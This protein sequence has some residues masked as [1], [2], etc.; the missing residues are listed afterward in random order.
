MHQKKATEKEAA[1]SRRRFKYE[2]HGAG[3]AHFAILNKGDD[4]CDDFYGFLKAFE[5]RLQDLP[6]GNFVIG[7]A[8]NGSSAGGR[9]V[10]KNFD[11]VNAL[12]IDRDGTGPTVKKLKALSV[13][14]DLIVHTSPNRFHAYWLVKDCT[15]KEFKR[16]QKL[17]AKK[18]GTDPSV[19]DVSR[20][21]RMPG[22]VNNKYDEPFYVWAEYGEPRDKALIPPELFEALGISLG[23]SATQADDAVNAAVKAQA[24]QPAATL[25]KLKPL[26]LSIP[27]D[28]RGIWMKVGQ[29]IH[30][31]LPS[32][33]GFK[34]WTDWSQSSAKFNAEEQRK[35]WDGF[36]SDREC[37]VTIASLYYYAQLYETGDAGLPPTEASLAEAFA[38]A[39]RGRFR[40][41]PKSNT[42]YVFDQGVWKKAHVEVQ[43]AARKLLSELSQLNAASAPR[44]R[45]FNNA[46]GF[47]AIVAHAQLL[48]ELHFDAQQLD[49]QPHLLAVANGVV[50]LRTGELRDGRPED[51]LSQQTPVAFDAQAECGRWIRFIKE[52]CCGEMDFAKFLQRALGL[53]LLGNTQEQKFFLLIG[54]GGNGKGV[55]MRIMST[56]LGPYAHAVAPNVLSRAFSGNPNAPSPALAPLQFA[57]LVVCSELQDGKMDEAFIKQFAGGD[58]M[59]ARQN[60]GELVTFTPP[61][62]LWV[63]T[64]HEPDLQADDDA[65]WRRIVP[66]P[67]RARWTDSDRD[68]NLEDE[69]RAELPGI[70]NWLLRGVARYHKEGLGSCKAV[71]VCN[72]QMKLTADTVRAWLKVCCRKG[73]SSLLQAGTAYMSYQRHTRASKREP[74]SNK[75]FPKVMEAKGFARRKRKDG[76]YFEGLKLID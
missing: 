2:L 41:D 28:D 43:M 64:N 30:S 3:P 16:L 9:R 47:K 17:L 61:G 35:T 14:P 54:S 38:K 44:S 5:K 60:Y 1:E 57:R 18:F 6:Q 39:Y 34:L 69:L 33:D 20:L 67:C 45:T 75:A 72:E 58:E 49:R 74:L 53:T 37:R 13:P 25:K 8:P 22:T 73:D 23:E 63:S 46:A 24:A 32:E 11:K 70:L 29:A 10:A 68:R 52:L 56:L 50:D 15:V 27:N 59:S 12:F 31:A 48:P 19:C 36:D 40:F 51:M 65:M 42:W 26:L 66:V 76:N 55:L 4:T 21:M 71:D 7:M 62:K